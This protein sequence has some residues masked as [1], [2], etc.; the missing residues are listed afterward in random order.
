MRIGKTTTAVAAILFLTFCLGYYFEVNFRQQMPDGGPSDFNVYYSAAHALLSGKS[1]FIDPGYLYPP[2]FAF[3]MTPFAVT[4]L[5]HAQWLWF[6]CSH[7]FLLISAWLVWRAAGRGW[8]AACVVAF[9][10]ACGGVASESLGDGQLGCLLMFLI[11][12]AYISAPIGQGIGA[13]VSACIKYFPVVLGAVFALER[14]WRALM[15]FVV[16]ALSGLLIPWIIILCCLEGPKST[17]NSYFWMGTPA[18]LSWSI[19]SSVLRNLDPPEQGAELPH[20]WLYGNDLGAVYL[21]M[22]QRLISISVAA[23]VLIA[24]FTALWVVSRGRFTALGQPQ[25]GGGPGSLSDNE[26]GARFGPASPTL[27]ASAAMIAVTLAASPICWTHY[28]ILDYPGVALLIVA[29]IRRRRWRTLAWAVVCYAFT[30]QVPVLVLRRYVQI[31]GGWVA[32]SPDTLYFWTSVTPLAN[33]ALAG[34]FLRMMR[35]ENS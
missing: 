28:Q 3:F 10:W 6:L 11:A 18:I 17:A 1:P 12:I 25:N 21:P 14:N 27:W 19:P 9:I 7:V 5:L 2:L 34:A 16:T 20:N 22:D 13:G 33:L 8:I 31:H 29:T 32:D 35:V 24:G 30:Y 26:A 23:I 4:S 15:A